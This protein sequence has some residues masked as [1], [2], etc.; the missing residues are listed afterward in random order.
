M[1][2]FAIIIATIFIGYLGY[3]YFLPTNKIKM[4]RGPEKYFHSKKMQKFCYALVKNDFATADKLSKNGLDINKK[5]TKVKNKR[6]D[7]YSPTPLVWLFLSQKDTPEKLKAFKY[8]LEHGANPLIPHDKYNTTMLWE[9]SGY[10][11]PDYLKAILEISKPSKEEMNVDLNTGTMNTPL[12]HAMA[13]L[14]FEN[15]KLLLDAGADMEYI[16]K[17]GESTLE[18]CSGRGTWRYALELLKRGIDYTKDFQWIKDM[19][20]MEG[21]GS[22]YSPVTALNWDGVDDR[23]KVVQFFREKGIEMKPGMN[24]GEKY[25]RE[26]GEDILYI[27]EALLYKKSLSVEEKKGRDKWIKFEDSEFNEHTTK[28]PDKQIYLEDKWK[29]EE[30]EN[31]KK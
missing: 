14:R 22:T 19:V 11:Y 23:Q 24:P 21:I 15:F 17:Y 27:N 8:L 25:V 30:K 16:D 10:E 31:S 20:E 5:G 2:I 29:N 13:T 1:K 9:A 6:K 12:L 28:D 18:K 3:Q 4:K 26:N 7:E